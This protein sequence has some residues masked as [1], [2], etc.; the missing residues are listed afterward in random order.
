MTST[1]KIFNIK[2]PQAIPSLGSSADVA[3][4]SLY[5]NFALVLPTKPDD[6]FCPRIIYTLSTI[7]HEDPFPAPGQNGQPRFSMKTYSENVGVLEQLEALGIL[8][9]TGIS[10]K[11]GFVDIPVVE[12]IL[13][14]NELVYACAAHYEDNGMM[15]CQLEVIGIKHQRCGKCKQVYYCDQECQKRHWPV[16]KKDCPIAQRSPTDGLALIENR[17]R[18][19]FSSFLSNAGFQTLNL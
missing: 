3:L 1:F 17:R 16:H 6:S 2:F 15:D 9:Q 14:E 5:G 8:R 13:K 11:Q 4:A 10:Y 19:G 12:V 7:V 18:A